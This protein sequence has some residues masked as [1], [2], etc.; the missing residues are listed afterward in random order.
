MNRRDGRAKNGHCPL[1]YCHLNTING[2]S[3]NKE[4]SVTLVYLVFGSPRS[5]ILST[6]LPSYI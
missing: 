4:L 3:P 6:H 2:E 5:T 1:R